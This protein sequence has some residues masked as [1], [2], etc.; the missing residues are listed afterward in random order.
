M[1]NSTVRANILL[2][3]KQGGLFM[4][5]FLR[6]LFSGYFIVLIILLLEL[7]IF[8]FIQFFLEDTV[9]FILGKAEE[10]VKLTVILVYLLLRIVVF[11]VAFFIFFRIVNKPEDPEFK[12]PWIVGMLLLPFFT[13]VVFLIFGNHG[14]N[15]RDK[16]IIGA[17]VNAYRSYFKLNKKE[18]AQVGEEL[19]RAYGTFKYVK[20]VTKLGAHKGNRVTYYKDGETFFPELIESLKL[21]EEFIFM[22]FFI[23]SDG[24]EWDAVKEILIQ[25]AK[26]GV[27]VRIV[28]DDMGCSGT[29]S[30]KTP[31]I[32]KQYGIKC[33]K[34]HPFRPIL[35]GV[36]NN[37]DHRKIVIIDH[38]MAFTGGMNLADEYAN[39]IKRFGYWKD[40]MVKIEGSAINNLLVIFLQNFNL[41][42]GWVSNFNKYLDYEYETYD[43]EGY[44][45][46]FGDGPGGIDNALIGEQTYINILNY[47]KEKVYISTPY[48]IPTYSLLDALRNAALR[49]VEVNLIVPGI[50][51]KKLAYWMA[52]SNF[53][54][55]LEAG[56]NI[57]TYT[58]GFNHMKTVIADNELAFVGTINFDF[59][60]LVH[61][62]EC[63][64]VLYKCNCMNEIT[65][66]FEQMIKVSKKVPQNYRFRGIKK[67]ICSVLKIISALF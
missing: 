23:I 17:T 64:A 37:R 41:C 33:Y 52:K 56:V 60:S 38:K 44:V 36:Y 3:N 12:I 65:E 45:M 18:I 40:T 49:G 13:S 42:A 30:P 53:R 2:T 34:F 22:E 66:D 55:L 19:D 8:I 21:A 61:H 54:F 29:I 57:Y 63:G 20:N 1:K 15:K 59:R 6:N 25:K 10:D 27:D 48:L 50:P 46:P 67:S 16:L 32:L 24:K 9:A 47:A 35:S 14:L 39:E 5:K 58:P 62:F 26:E 11:F 43:D 4:K 7:A 28:Y 31:R 51:D